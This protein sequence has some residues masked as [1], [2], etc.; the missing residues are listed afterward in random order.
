M[1]FMTVSWTLEAHADGEFNY[2]VILLLILA[3]LSVGSIL[4]AW[5]AYVQSGPVAEM[6]QIEDPH[7]RD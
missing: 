2:Q 6:P 5:R 7:A 3:L 4:R 1:L